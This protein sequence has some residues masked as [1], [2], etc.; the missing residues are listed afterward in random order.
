LHARNVLIT[1]ESGAECVGGAYTWRYV[2]A[3]D[4]AGA[5]KAAI[6]S[7]RKTPA[8]LNEVRNLEEALSDVEV[9]E[10]VAMEREKTGG[11]GVVFYIDTDQLM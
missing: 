1:D 7:L 8:F 4:H 11:T 5:A 2:T 10:I 3:A 9:E 6:E